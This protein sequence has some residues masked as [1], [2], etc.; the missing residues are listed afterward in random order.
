MDKPLVSIIIPTRDRSELL[1][2]CLDCLK[3]QTYKN[4]EIIVVDGNSELNDVEIAKEYTDKVFVFDKKGDHRCAQRN[5]GVKKASGKYVLIIDSDM[6][7]TEKVIESCV[8]IM[9]ADNKTRGV[10]IPERSIGK[11]FWAKCKA[12]EKSFYA[13]VDWM[14]AARFFKC[15]D[16]LQVN[17]YNENMTSGE[18]W[19]LSQR[20]GGLGKIKRTAEFLNHNEGRISLWKTV[21]NKYYY[22]GE[23][24]KYMRAN[25]DTEA[26]NKQTGILARY[27]LFFNDPIKLFRNPLVGLGMLFMKSCEFGFGGVGYLLEVKN[28]DNK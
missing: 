14:E 2:R 21:R 3:N 17:G 18:D 1:R 7:L 11:G 13:G 8:D 9:E 12:L 19:D 28:I 6:E 26:M 22:A 20:I 5:L 16:F 4:I 23:F 10:T 24:A 25:R 27:K 15:E